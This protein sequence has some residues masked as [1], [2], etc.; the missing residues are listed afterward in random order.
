V[1]NPHQIPDYIVIGA[2]SSGCVVVNRLSE[3]P[4]VRVL[5]IEAGA[6]G[7]ADSAVT[8][9]GRWVSL[10]GSRYDWGYATAPE[11]GMAN[12][13]IGFPRGKAHG[14]S[15]AINAMVHIRGHRQC[16][17]R[18]Q[19]SGNPGW[20]YED[21]LPLFK[22][23]ERHDG[24]SSRYRG[25]DG[26]LAVSRGL[27]PHASHEAFLRA[28]TSFGFRADAQHDF[29]GP[30]PEG[31]AG[32]F[33]KNIMNGR[34]HS[35]AA[36]YLVPALARPNVEVRSPAQAT[37]LILEGRRIVGVEYLQDGRLERVRASREVVLC[38][39]AVDSPR[40][41]MLSGIGEAA[42]LRAHGIAVAADL[43]GVGRN[44]QDHLKLAIRWNG[45]T[46]LPGSTV[47]A[48]LFTSSGSGPLPDL[49][50]Y[51]GRGIDQPDAFITITVS[52]VA[53]RSRGE[54]RLQSA[55]PLVAPF[56]RAN[57]L[58][59][60]ADVE[61]LVVGARLAR[62]L[63]HS[64]AYDGLRGDEIE[65]G[66]AA[67]SDADL[68]GFARLKADTIYHAAGTC[69]MGPAS[70]PDAVVDAQLRVHGLDGLRVTDA[71]IMPEA[72]NAP[73]HA[74]CVA[75]GEKYASLV[76]GTQVDVFR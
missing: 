64:P 35:A 44:L 6:S 8:T 14:G 27:D 60:Q 45:T 50:F 20:G 52:L 71:S 56:I 28:A 39:G 10:M 63:G 43:P 66:P 16:F 34:R 30:E 13:C 70:D 11:P 38:A 46:T 21:L 4:S 73:T 76:A 69:R 59:E 47:T 23:S 17:D 12:R 55:D 33:Q 74:A 67:T 41:L 62:S 31:V 3:D 1:P 68:V 5:L 42:H 24:G 7:E 65:P 54:V 48:G 36:A 22:R 25:A 58:Q 61:A 32:F 26:P 72:V 9:P 18:W 29:N 2:G 15:S 51:V 49:Q 75:I 37:R 40:L 57:Y 53:P 19:A